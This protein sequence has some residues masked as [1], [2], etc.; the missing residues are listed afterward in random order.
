MSVVTHITS[1]WDQT[2]AMAADFA[3]K[4]KS[5]FHGQEDRCII[6]DILENCDAGTI[7]ECRVLVQKLEL[8][9]LRLDQLHVQSNQAHLAALRGLKAGT[10]HKAVLSQFYK[11]KSETKCLSDQICETILPQLSD[12]IYSVSIETV[13]GAVF[14]VIGKIETTLDQLERILSLKDSIKQSRNSRNS[15]NHITKAVAATDQ[16]YTFSTFGES[17]GRKRATHSHTE[18]PQRRLHQDQQL[19]QSKAEYWRQ[20]S[21]EAASNQALGT[22]HGQ[23][24]KFDLP[25]YKDDAHNSEKAV[26][27]EHHLLSR[28]QSTSIHMNFDLINDISDDNVS[29]IQ[30]KR[31]KKPKRSSY[32]RPKKGPETRPAN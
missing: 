20:A 7:K 5:Y 29:Q 22:R 26:E 32:S 31:P 23:S 24:L 4:L 30:A 2:Q 14:K 8:T 13:K 21:N 27:P 17:A 18:R 12:S 28:D 1:D 10:S 9:L 15:S 11:L 25:A 16:L 6:Q 19:P 3:H